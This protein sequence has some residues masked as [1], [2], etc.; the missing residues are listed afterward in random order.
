[1]S[2]TLLRS[3]LACRKRILDKEHERILL[4]KL[5]DSYQ[6]SDLS[7]PPNCHGYGRIHH[8]DRDEGGNWPEDP[9]PNDPAC[10][11]LGIS[12]AKLVRAEVFQCA[13]C[14]F[15]CWYCFV[16]RELR[17]ADEN[18][19]AWFSPDELIEAYLAI[20]NRPSIVDLSGGNPGLVPEW[21][22]WTARALQQHDLSQSVYLWSDDNL[23]T[24]FHWRFLNGADRRL[25]TEFGHY[26]QVACFKGFDETSFAFNTQLSPGCFQDQFERMKGLLMLGLDQYAYVTLTCPTVEDIEG[27]MAKFVDHLQTLAETLPLRTVPLKIECYGPTQDMMNPERTASLQNQF[28]AVNVWQM[29]IE[30]RFSKVLRSMSIVDVPLS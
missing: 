12:D 7:V 1:M 13:Q 14:N 23:S 9:L 10:R 2:G 8:F 21:V 4:A 5:S 3:S 22:V 11:A 6:E 18:S 17:R 25:L 29:E 16:P 28:T 30:T 26:G 20:P 24:D 15:D 27:R 19:T